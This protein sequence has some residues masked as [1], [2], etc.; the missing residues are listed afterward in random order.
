MSEEPR[1]SEEDKTTPIGQMDAAGE[2]NLRERERTIIAAAQ[3]ANAAIE[4]PAE[5]VLEAMVALVEARADWEQHQAK[6]IAALG[7]HDTTVEATGGEP[8]PRPYVGPWLL[9][10]HGAVSHA[11]RD[12]T[13]NP[14]SQEGLPSELSTFVEDWV[15]RLDGGRRRRDQEHTLLEK[16]S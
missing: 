15:R 10:Q 1:Q 13:L 5:R 7:A 6:V 9:Q 14:V 8:F 11:L 16:A 2:A 4:N 12:A 3:D